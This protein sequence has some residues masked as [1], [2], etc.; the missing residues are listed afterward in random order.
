MHNKKSSYVQ[1]LKCGA[2]SDKGIQL[3][4]V[5]FIIW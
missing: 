4:N 1:M 3:F 2:I 5:V